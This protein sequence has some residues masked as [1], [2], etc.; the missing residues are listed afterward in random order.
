VSGGAGGGFIDD[1]DNQLEHVAAELGSAA[2]LERVPSWGDAGWRIVPTRAGASAVWVEANEYPPTVDVSFGRGESTIIEL[3]YE[4]KL[5]RAGLV[6]QLE[7]VVRAV[8]A[9]RLVE[10]VKRSGASRFWLTLEDGSVLR[11][12]GCFSARRRA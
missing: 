4:G 11:G 8:I 5:A 7:A 6:Q 10:H 3:G 2:R 12:G 1:I 9:G